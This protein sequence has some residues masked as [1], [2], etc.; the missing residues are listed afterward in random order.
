MVN[1]A[2]VIPQ[3]KE[4]IEY[5]EAKKNFRIATAKSRFHLH[6]FLY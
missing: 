6:L 1:K 4:Q 5:E 3:T 2:R